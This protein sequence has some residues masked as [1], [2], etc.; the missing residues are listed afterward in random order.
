MILETFSE[1]CDN[2]TLTTTTG[3]NFE[4]KSLDLGSVSP[5]DIG[6]GEPLYLVV[7]VTTGIA[8]ASS[9]GT[10][11]V[12]LASDAGATLT[13]STATKHVSSP[14]FATSTS[15]IAAGTRLLAVQLPEG[16]N[17]FERYLGIVVQIETTA[18]N[19]GAISA[20]LTK[21]PPKHVAYADGAPV[22]S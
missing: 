10:L 3:F 11:T 22:L 16:G 8:T 1:F 2:D 20:Y 5:G 9:T 21:A 18:L 17:A 14:P 4:G 13:G 6:V 19:A 7:E 12:H 15:A